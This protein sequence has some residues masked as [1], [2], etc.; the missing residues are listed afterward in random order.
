MFA[1]PLLG[2]LVVTGVLA[3]SACVDSQQV[4]EQEYERLS[5]SG[6]QTI[7]VNFI[8][9]IDQVLSEGQQVD[10]HDI[11]A[12]NQEIQA[13]VATPTADNVQACRVVGYGSKPCSGPSSW[14]IYSSQTTDDTLLLPL[15]ERYNRL[16][17]QFNQQE[18]MMS[19]CAMLEPVQPQLINGVCVAGSQHLFE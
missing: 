16:T 1:K 17:E 10:R 12:L 4:A 19:H 13:L 11:S 3:L 6:Y 15:V 5:E 18:G 2:A 8:E 9:H 7:D 14:L